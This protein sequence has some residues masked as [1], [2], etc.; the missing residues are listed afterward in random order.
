MVLREK[1]I[2]KLLEYKAMKVVATASCKERFKALHRGKL[3][4]QPDIEILSAY[5]S[6]VRGLYNFYSIANNYK[7]SEDLPT[8]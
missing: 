7:K 2:G 3:I 1:W 4:N 6:E 8:S 5:N